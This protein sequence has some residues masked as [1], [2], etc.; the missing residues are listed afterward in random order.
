MIKI[1]K[2][3]IKKN[4]KVSEA[5][6]E[7][8]INNKHYKNKG[9]WNE[10]EGRFCA[11]KSKR[12]IL[13]ESV[14]K[15]YEF[16]YYD[17]ERIKK[18][19][20][21]K[22][23]E[24]VAMFLTVLYNEHFNG[25]KF[26]DWDN[27][28]MSTED[29]K[30][31]LKDDYN[32][33]LDKLKDLEIISIDKQVNIKYFKRGFCK[34][35]K[36]NED[37]NNV[38]GKIYEERNIKQ[39]KYE[40]R[41]MNFYL[42]TI[43]ERE[44][45]EKYVEEVLDKCTF[46]LGDKLIDK[47]N[48]LAESK[49]VKENDRLNNS[50]LSERDK[51]EIELKIGDKEKFEKEYLKHANDYYNGL[52]IKLNGIE[53]VRKYNYNIKVDVYG[54]R[55]SHIVSSMPKIYR[56]ELKIDGEELVEIDIVSSQ[57]AF[58]T[59]LLNKL[60][61]SGEEF[62]SFMGSS[63]G[64]LSFDNLKKGVSENVNAPQLLIEKLEMMYSEDSLTEQMSS[65]LDLYKFMGVKLKGLKAMGSDEIRTEMKGVFMGLLFGST[66]FEKYK[67]KDRK[68][69]IHE[70]FGPDFFELLQSIERLDVEGIEKKKYRNLSAL[71]QREESKFLN[72]VMAELM[73]DEVKFLPLYDCLIVKKRDKERVE[74]A[75]N[76]VI[77]KNGYDGIIKVK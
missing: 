11:N 49:Y 60:F 55:L 71:L 18:D 72:E 39:K 23:Y 32:K 67:G 66:K 27:V 70:V 37:F 21:S 76:S 25:R 24:W 9:Y 64:G 10:I 69:I 3:K 57:V 22:I 26:S 75:F 47:N 8:L 40:D 12:E 4:L 48:E 33:I 20:G 58:L 45:V 2:K 17:F 63:F 15:I 53:W 59:I 46:D 74:E 50:F 52:M 7:V 43:N 34:Y 13:N 6:E 51:K 35:I 44:G 16:K 41:I 19:F 28:Y 56:K 73:K 5:V 62:E 36:L 42:K 65:E 1:L 54:N 14:L 77:A 30:L 29:L 61:D 31:Y 38:E 68:E